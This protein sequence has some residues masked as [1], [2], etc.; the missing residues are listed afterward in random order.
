MRRAVSKYGSTATAAVATSASATE[1]KVS[2]NSIQVEHIRIDSHKSYGD[3]R[4][5]LEK[6]PR[7]DV[8]FVPFCTM[9]RSRVSKPN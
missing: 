1:P 2:R 6:L 8:E 3:V 4:A 5:A 9:G 7:F